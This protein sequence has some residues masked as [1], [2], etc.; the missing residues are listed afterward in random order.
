[1]PAIDLTKISIHPLR[2]EELQIILQNFSGEEIA[3][4][5]TLEELRKILRKLREIQLQEHSTSKEALENADNTQSTSTQT[6]KTDTQET[7]EE[8]KKKRR[9]FRNRNSRKHGSQRRH[10]VQQ[11]STHGTNL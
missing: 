6:T 10:G 3:D 9:N 11:K 4:A 8:D 5:L 1:M 2:K 7:K